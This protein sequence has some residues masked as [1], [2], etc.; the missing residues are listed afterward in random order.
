MDNNFNQRLAAQQEQRRKEQERQDRLYEMVASMQKKQAEQ[1]A[2]LTQIANRHIPTAS[3]VAEHIY[4]PSNSIDADDLARALRKSERENSSG[5]NK[6]EIILCAEVAAIFIL[7]IVPIYQNHQQTVLLEHIYDAE[8][9]AGNVPSKLSVE[10]YKEHYPDGV[11]A[12]HQKNEDGT[13]KLDQDGNQMWVYDIQA[14]ITAEQ[15][16]QV[17]P[18]LQDIIKRTGHIGIKE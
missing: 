1:D 18:Q 4:I 2:T 3:E 12:I 17:R 15:W 10:W 16:E 7:L 8:V 11:V 13:N 9:L 5:I 6:A 14:D